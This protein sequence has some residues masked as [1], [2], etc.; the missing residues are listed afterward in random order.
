M[1]SIKTFTIDNRNIESTLE[2]GEEDGGG[3]NSGKFSLYSDC[4]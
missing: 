3:P 2:E 1:F 4:Q